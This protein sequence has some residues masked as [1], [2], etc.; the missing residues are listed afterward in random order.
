MFSANTSIRE[1]IGFMERAAYTK[2]QSEAYNKWKIDTL[3]VSS[4]FN[5]AKEEGEHNK[6]VEVALRTLEMGLTIEDA[7]KLSGLPPEQINEIRKS[8]LSR[9]NSTV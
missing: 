2:A 8:A 5:A 7:S 9:L 6:A 4:M 3:T 1:A